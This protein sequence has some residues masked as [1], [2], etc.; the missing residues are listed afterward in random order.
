[1]AFCSIEGEVDDD[2]EDDD[3]PLAAAAKK[4]TDDELVVAVERVLDGEDVQT[5][6]IKALMKRLGTTCLPDCKSA[7]HVSCTRMLS[8]HLDFLH[9]ATFPDCLFMSHT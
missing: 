4:P 6:N 2:D 7:V 9:C 3:M 8:Q 1:M 5:F